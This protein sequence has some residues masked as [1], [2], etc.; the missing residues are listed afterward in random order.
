MREYIHPVC[1][2]AIVLF[3]KVACAQQP[4]LD[5][6][7]GVGSYFNP[8]YGEKY[9]MVTQDG[10][11]KKRGQSPEV[12]VRILPNSD[13]EVTWAYKQIDFTRTY[14]VNSQG[15]VKLKSI[16]GFDCVL[17]GTTTRR[18]GVTI[19][20]EVALTSRETISAP[21]NDDNCVNK[22]IIDYDKSTMTFDPAA[23][24]GNI[25]GLGRTGFP[26]IG[27]GEI[28]NHSNLHFRLSRIMVLEP[29][30]EGTIL[31]RLWIGL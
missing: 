9:A 8:Y 25:I 18:F 7:G 21:Q 26:I 20:D 19:A 12:D 22:D 28:W 15:L 14:F 27:V 6:W 13:V 3:A 24:S 30:K 1:M 10:F 31:P 23:A 4:V 17:E 29:S 11:H 2:L 5:D 16:S